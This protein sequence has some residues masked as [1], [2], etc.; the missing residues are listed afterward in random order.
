[1]HTHKTN[2]LFKIIVE[3]GHRMDLSSADIAI[4]LSVVFYVVFALTFTIYFKRLPKDRRDRLIKRMRKLLKAVSPSSAIVEIVDVLIEKRKGLPIK[5][6]IKITSETEDNV[7][8]LSQ[9]IKDLSKSL[10]NKPFI[11][12]TDI[13][14]TLDR[15]SLASAKT[16]DWFAKAFFAFTLAF[17]V[18]LLALYFGKIINVSGLLFALIPT[19]I[20]SISS[21]ITVLLL[22]DLAYL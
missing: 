7:G 10:E 2:I 17:S 12:K 20:L 15:K 14:V 19:I 6:N 16:C 21:L 4:I 22:K 5:S 9:Q 11:V 3:R 1:M 8:R 13:G 18:T